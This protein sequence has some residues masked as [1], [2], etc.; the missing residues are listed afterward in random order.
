[1]TDFLTG[2]M[3]GGSLTALVLMAVSRWSLSKAFQDGLKMGREM[4]R[5]EVAGEVIGCLWSEGRE[6]ELP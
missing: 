2:A 6:G 5:A 1:M 4:G 3:F